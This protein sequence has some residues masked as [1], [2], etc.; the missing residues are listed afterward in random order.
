MALWNGV[1]Q[2]ASVAQLAGVDAYGLIK[3]IVEAVQTVRRNKETC[4]KLAQRVEMIGNLLQQFQ[5]AQLMQYHDTRNP[6][7][8][9]EHTLQRA[10]MLITSCQDSSFVYHCFTG[11]NK[12]DQFREVENDITFYLQLFPL[13]GYVDTTRTW[14]R[15]LNGGQPSHTE[16]SVKQVQ[17]LENDVGN[18]LRHEGTA[19]TVESR[20]HEVTKHSTDKKEEIA[21]SDIFYEPQ[22]RKLQRHFF[23]NKDVVKLFCAERC[24]GLQLFNFSQI[25]DFT[26]N[27][28]GENVIGCGAFGY[29]YKGKLPDENETAVKRLA[30]TSLQ[31]LHEFTTEIE[32]IATLQHKNVIRHLDFAF[33]GK[34]TF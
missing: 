1:G 27:F 23:V 13:V 11:A 16:E 25:V 5:E 21:R 32:M 31:G 15:N 8:Q 18:V 14:V 4:Q 17:I 10:Y 26:E 22:K 7:E 24:S 30:A 33:K 19:E 2:V 3:M 12:A 20:S 34:S 6:V 28:K 29:V 9:L